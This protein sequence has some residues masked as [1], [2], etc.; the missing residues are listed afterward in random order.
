MT[1]SQVEVR[2]SFDV[3]DDRPAQWR[4]TSRI[5]DPSPRFRAPTMRPLAGGKAMIIV[6]DETGLIVATVNAGIRHHD[7]RSARLLTT[8]KCIRYGI[9]PT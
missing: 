7:A 8:S 1:C 3:P 5:R 2:S 9:V 6:I 4:R